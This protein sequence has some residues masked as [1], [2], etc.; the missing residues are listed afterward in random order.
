MMSPLTHSAAMGGSIENP[1]THAYQ[2]KLDTAGISDGRDIIGSTF[3]TLMHS[4]PV[5]RIHHCTPRQLQKLHRARL[6]VL[7]KNLERLGQ[8]GTGSSNFLSQA[9]PTVGRLLEYIISSNPCPRSMANHPP[10]GNL[11]KI[12]R[13]QQAAQLTIHNEYATM[14]TGQKYGQLPKEKPNN[15]IWFMYKNFSSLSLFTKGPKKHVKIR[16]LNKLMKEYSVDI[17]ARCKM[18]TDWR[19]ITDKDSKF[20]N[21]FGNGQP[22]WGVHAH[23]TNDHMIKRDQWGGCASLH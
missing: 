16:Q 10:P 23:N 14:R 11:V 9:T 2:R 17:L 7:S 3:D 1:Y 20:H 13:V 18:R 22:S 5:V 19:F 15:V 12:V 4:C 8:F 21:L 6:Y